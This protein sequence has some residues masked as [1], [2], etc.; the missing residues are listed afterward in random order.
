MHKNNKAKPNK[1]NKKEKTT[2]NHLS[3]SLIGVTMKS[4]TGNV[5]GN[6]SNSISGRF[7]S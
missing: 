7:Q 1:S 2:K 4:S 5:T 3:K 6:V